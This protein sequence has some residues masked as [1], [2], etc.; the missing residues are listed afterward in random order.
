MSIHERYSTLE[1]FIHDPIA[2][3]LELDHDA[4][5]PEPQPISSDPQVITSR[6]YHMKAETKCCRQVLCENGPEIADSK[7]L[8]E[9]RAVGLEKEVLSFPAILLPRTGRGKLIVTSAILIMVI[10]IGVGTGIG[11][12]R[13]AS[14]SQSGTQVSTTTSR[15]FR[16]TIRCVSRTWCIAGHCKSLQCH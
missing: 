9:V 5:A 7:I 16:S 1:L 11:I 3:G 2:N 4:N 15:L 12:G 8:P 10:C 6:K 13:H 14:Q